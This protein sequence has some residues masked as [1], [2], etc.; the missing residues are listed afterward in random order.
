MTQNI[1][2]LDIDPD[3]I[4]NKR[5]PRLNVPCELLGVCENTAL[6]ETVGVCRAQTRMMHSPDRDAVSNHILNMASS[7]PQ[8]KQSPPGG[9]PPDNPRDVQI[10]ELFD[11]VITVEA[12]LEDVRRW[13]RGDSVA[14]LK[15]TEII[16]SPCVECEAYDGIA[17]DFE[18]SKACVREAYQ[19]FAGMVSLET[20]RRWERVIGILPTKLEKAPR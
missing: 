13:I 10:R 15:T 1:N 12:R 4:E 17:A 11:R 19:Q 8:T 9:P 18:E 16:P 2:G 7:D 6:P 20:R 3:P 14:R 5:C